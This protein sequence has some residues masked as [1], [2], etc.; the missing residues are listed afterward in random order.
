MFGGGC[1]EEEEVVGGWKG[2]VDCIGTL[3]YFFISQVS[4]I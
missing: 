3:G 4:V 2:G 1:R